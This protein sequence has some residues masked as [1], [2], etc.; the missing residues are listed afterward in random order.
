MK[1]LSSL[2]TIHT[3]IVIVEQKE[4][5]TN[6]NNFFLIFLICP[7]QFFLKVD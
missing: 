6:M 1:Y 4:K 3:F 2:T 7:H 5:K